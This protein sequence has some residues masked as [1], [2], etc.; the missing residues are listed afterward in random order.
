AASHP[1]SG[2]GEGV[3]LS[4]Q[5]RVTRRL[6]RHRLDRELQRVLQRVASR[7]VDLRLPALRELPEPRLDRRAEEV[8]HARRE[9][10]ML[11]GVTRDH[12]VAEE[13]AEAFALMAAISGQP[14]AFMSKTAPCAERSSREPW[15]RAR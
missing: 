1:R 8:G 3:E 11:K 14:S 15:G 10:R 12:G 9:A 13:L 7:L 2:H 6:P 5:R 4:R